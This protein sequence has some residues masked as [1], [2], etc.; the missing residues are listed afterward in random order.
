MK[1]AAHRLRRRRPRFSA[2]S[3]NVLRVILGEADRRRGSPTV[4]VIEANIDDL[5]PQVLAYAMERLLESGALDVT[6]AA[7]AS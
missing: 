2:S 7:H 1:I 6:L 4:S 5:N 3:A